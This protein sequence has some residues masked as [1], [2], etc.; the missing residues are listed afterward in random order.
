[1]F[2]T[3]GTLYNALMKY[4]LS[5]GLI[6][7]LAAC[8]F[9]PIAVSVP[10]ISIPAESSGDDVCYVEIQES[11]EVGFNQVLYEADALYEP[12][13]G[14]ADT[15]TMVVYGRASD[16]NPGSSQEI[17]CVTLTDEDLALSGEI[18]LQAGESKRIEVGGD[19]LADLVTQESYW[20]GASLDDDSLFS[21]PGNIS[22][23]DGVVKAFF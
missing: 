23:T 21:F 2:T 17:K 4:L 7:L 10:D 18:T 13:L 15:V 14:G 3:L 11:T 8:S 9:A 6:L 19:T 22:F 12:G 1:M 16:P 20:L 5:A